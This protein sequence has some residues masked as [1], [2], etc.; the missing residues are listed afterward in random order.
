M[1]KYGKYRSIQEALE[2]TQG[3]ILVQETIEGVIEN[4]QMLRRDLKK[5]TDEQPDGYAINYELR[6]CLIGLNKVIKQLKRNKK[7]H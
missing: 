2:A 4:I 3:G 1:A 6:V 7:K 5:P